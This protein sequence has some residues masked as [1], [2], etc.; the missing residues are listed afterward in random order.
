MLLIAFM[1]LPDDCPRRVIGR[2]EF[3]SLCVDFLCD[4]CCCFVR[5][6][7][8]YLDDNNRLRKLCGCFS[9]PLLK[10]VMFL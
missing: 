9:Y 4:I 6:R 8:L 7:L 1:P 5:I 3:N 10:L 2:Y